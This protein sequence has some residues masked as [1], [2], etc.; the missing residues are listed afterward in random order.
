M[1]SRRRLAR[2]AVCLAWGFGLRVE[3][4]TTSDVEH[5][6]LH[7]RLVSFVILRSSS[8]VASAARIAVSSCSLLGVLDAQQQPGGAHSSTH[9]VQ[10]SRSSFKLDRALSAVGSCVA[11]P[12][13][14]IRWRLPSALSSL[15]CGS[16]R[17]APQTASSCPRSVCSAPTEASC[18]S[19]RRPTPAGGTSTRRS[20]LALPWT[21]CSGP[22]GSTPPW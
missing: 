19:W 20:R 14:H 16:C 1:R 11:E 4:G 12:R 18:Q 8:F 22:S 10:L 13:C 2:C 17:L 9:D 3:D 21:G 7:V 6:A 5:S 15:G